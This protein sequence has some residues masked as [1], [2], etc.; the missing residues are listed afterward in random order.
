MKQGPWMIQEYLHEKNSVLITS[1][2]ENWAKQY[3]ILRTLSALQM[4]QV[5]IRKMTKD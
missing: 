1:G 3:L 2:I 4:K 5:F